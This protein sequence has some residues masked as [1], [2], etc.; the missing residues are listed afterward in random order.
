M[1]KKVMR[2]ADGMTFL[3]QPNLSNKLY[4]RGRYTGLKREMEQI[5]V[6][7]DS[8]GETVNRAVAIIGNPGQQDGVRLPD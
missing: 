3:G 1:I 6:P 2:L 5:F 8:A 4:R 7:K